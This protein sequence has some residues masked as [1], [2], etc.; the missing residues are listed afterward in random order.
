[1]VGLPLVVP[2]VT[3]VPAGVEVALGSPPEFA[4]ELVAELVAACV[5]RLADEV[6]E[7]F[8]LLWYQGLTLEEAAGVLEVSQRAIQRRWT[9][10]M[11]ILR[12]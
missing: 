10:G 3:S 12:P 1:M 11:Y 2:V 4:A 9:A 6:R 7:V 8:E 5:E